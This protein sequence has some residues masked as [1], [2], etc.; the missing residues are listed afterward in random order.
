M[1]SKIEL[2]EGVSVNG[3]NMMRALASILQVDTS[4]QE[5]EMWTRKEVR[6]GSHYYPLCNCHFLQRSI[7]GECAVEYA[8]LKGD[9]AE[10][11]EVSKTV[12]HLKDCVKRNFKVFDNSDA[13]SCNGV[14]DDLYTTMSPVGQEVSDDQYDNVPHNMYKS[15][16]LYTQHP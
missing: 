5:M 15:Q 2:P 9:E 8:F 1:V 3:K 16:N 6:R 13:Y 11:M 4:V 14:R 10:V 7:H 12:S